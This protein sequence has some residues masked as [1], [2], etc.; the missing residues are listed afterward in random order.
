[1]IVYTDDNRHFNILS[2]NCYDVYSSN[3][4]M[5]FSKSI[6]SNI[7]NRQYYRVRI[8][9]DK[10]YELVSIDKRLNL[11]SISELNRILSG[12]LLNGSPDSLKR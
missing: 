10:A 7:N 3:I 2:S 6:D 11:K 8:E 4:E 9:K 1:M 5:Y 12:G